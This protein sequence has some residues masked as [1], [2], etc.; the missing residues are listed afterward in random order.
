MYALLILKICDVEMGY[1]NSVT[2]PRIPES[3]TVILDIKD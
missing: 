3:G 2:R 1:R